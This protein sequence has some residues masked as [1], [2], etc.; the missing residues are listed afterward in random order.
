MLSKKIVSGIFFT[1]F[2]VLLSLWFCMASY[3]LWTCDKESASILFHNPI[4]NKSHYIDDNNIKANLQ[5]V[6]HFYPN[7]SL[8]HKMNYSHSLFDAFALKVNHDETNN[9]VDTLLK[10]KRYKFTPFN[11][12][13]PHSINSIPFEKNYFDNKFSVFQDDTYFYTDMPYDKLR[14]LTHDLKVPCFKQNFYETVYQHYPLLNNEPL[15]LVII[16]RQE[17]YLESRLIGIGFFSNITLKTVHYDDKAIVPRSVHEDV[18]LSRRKAYQIL[19]NRNLNGGA[20]SHS[21]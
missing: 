17:P 16:A 21:I 15:N 9:C 8:L 13:S 12:K 3:F 18:E 14:F 1:F 4:L 11:T 20:I 7:S 2:L 6:S 5:K 10:Q 19:N